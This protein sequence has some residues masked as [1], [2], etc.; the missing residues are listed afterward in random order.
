RGLTSGH[1]RTVRG[2]VEHVNFLPAEKFANH[3]YVEL[4]YQGETGHFFACLDHPTYDRQIDRR[5]QESR[6]IV[7][8][9][10]LTQVDLLST[11]SD[12]RHTGLVRRRARGGGSGPPMQ[13]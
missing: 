1:R 11:L 13:R 12:H 9:S 10:R 8:E 2:N 7:N 4:E 3:G 5:Q 6:L